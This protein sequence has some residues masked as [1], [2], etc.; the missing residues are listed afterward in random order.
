MDKIIITDLQAYGIIGVKHPER[1]QPQDLL[2]NLTLY[3]DLHAA[4][5]SDSILDTINYSS[6]SKVI[7][8]EI[9]Q[10]QF[11][12]VEALAAH[13]AHLLLNIFPA[14]SVRIRIEKP[15]KV[16]QTTRVGIEI[17]RRKSDY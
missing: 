2:I 5:E 14:T 11:H 4:G 6:L 12:T 16:A 9:A 1:D 13:L 15:K 10:T 17:F 7:I 8:N 3:L